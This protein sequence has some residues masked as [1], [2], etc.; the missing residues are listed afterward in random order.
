[1]GAEIGA[2]VNRA[3]RAAAMRCPLLPDEIAREMLAALDGAHQVQPYS[4]RLQ[5]FDLPQAYR[6]TPL[7]RRLREARGERVTGRKI[8]F[9]NRTIW[10]QYGVYAPIWGYMYD[11]SVHPLT[12]AA[13]GVALAPF[14]EPLIEPEIAFRFARAPQPDMDD[15]AILECVEWIAHGFE[16]V[17]SHYAGWKFAAADTVASGGLHG[18]YYLGPQ[19][20]PAADRPRWLATLKDFEV[21]LYRDGVRMDR[22]FAGTVLDGPLSAIRHLTGVLADD[23]HNPPVGAGE[24][25]TTGTLTRAFPVKPGERWRTEMLGIGLPGN[26]IGFC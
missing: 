14:I 12:D 2:Q 26:E 20:D 18:A 25:I 24:I 7:L 19:A 3:A 11:T 17:Q 1:M 4:Q 15:A 21:L 23:P 6:V 22:G 10:E 9:T 13:S 5:A 8:G 16:I